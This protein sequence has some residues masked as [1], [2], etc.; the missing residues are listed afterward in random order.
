MIELRRVRG[1]LDDTQLAWVSE[2]YGPVDHKYRSLGYLRHQLVDNPFGWSLHVFALDGERAVGHC[3]V[4]P[5]R[6]RRGDEEL[7]VGKLEGLAFDSAYRGRRADGGSNAVD[8]LAALYEHA[9]EHGLPIVFGLA[10]PGVDRIH[11]RAGCR[12]VPVDAPAY[13][14]VTDARAFARGA[15]RRRR[16]A[17]TALSVAQRTLATLGGAI[18]PAPGASAE[19]PRESD[20]VLGSATADDG[21]WTVSGA[22]AWDWYVGS[23]VLRVVEV[24]GRNG[25]RA[26]VK[27]ADDETAQIVAWR[28]RRAGLAPALA[29]LRALA[30]LAR[31]HRAPTL[32]FQP[33]PGCD[34]GGALSRACRL[35][36]LVRR[37]EVDL[38]VHGDEE[39]DAFRLTPFFYVTF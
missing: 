32:R 26:L 38:V 2:L 6:A 7:A 30:R 23:G 11:V 4:V 25:S 13:V 36:G 3:C 34:P 14:L 18:L 12:Q 8:L 27:L 35:A 33:W 9:H 31:E 20:A 24:P 39:L 5:F 37:A 19:T 29:L 21:R 15:G 10:P 22:D 28:P 16:L 17:A 1:P